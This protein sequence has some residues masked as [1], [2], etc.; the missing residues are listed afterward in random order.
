MSKTSVANAFRE[1]RKSIMSW[2]GLSKYR[3]SWIPYSLS[4]RRWMTHKFEAILWRICQSIWSICQRLATLNYLRNIAIH[5]G[6][7]ENKKKSDKSYQIW[8]QRK[9]SLF[10]SRECVKKYIWYDVFWGSKKVATQVKMGWPNPDQLFLSISSE[11]I[12]KSLPWGKKF[13]Q[14]EVCAKIQSAG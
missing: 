2:N 14:E 9:C 3:K 5:I 12:R 6:C 1:H 10:I 8:K 13:K 4:Q 7:Y 11:K